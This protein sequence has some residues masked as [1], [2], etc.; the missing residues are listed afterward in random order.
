MSSVVNS[1][2]GTPSSG[3]ASVNRAVTLWQA[4]KNAVKRLLP[5]TARR[6]IY[7]KRWSPRRR[8]VVGR[9]RFGSFRQLEPID[10]H[11][12]MQWGQC[13]DRYYIESFLAEHEANVHGCVLEVSDNVYTRRFGRDR[14]TKSDI[15]HVTPG[16]P[17]AT[18]TADLTSA[19]HLPSDTYD[20]IILTQTLQFI[21]NVPAAIR[22]LYRILKPGGVLLATF[23]GTSKIARYDMDRWGEYWRFTTLSARKLF[24]EVFPESAV[25][26]RSYGNVLVAIAFLEGLVS[27]ELRREELDHCDP[28]YEVL[29]AVRAVKPRQD[30][31]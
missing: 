10:R 26:V 13:I 20:C 14:V 24:T 31:Q 22:T 1:S 8:P 28:D 16:H 4:M 23:H 3:A 11:F 6:R 25:T 2:L 21:Y 30:S 15:L 27:A 12:G 5:E 9:V 18:V 29:V 17:R 19:D 7:D